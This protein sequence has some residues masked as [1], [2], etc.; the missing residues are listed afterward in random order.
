[1]GVEELEV[2]PQRVGHEH[3]QGADHQVHDEDYNPGRMLLFKHGGKTT[4]CT[5][6]ERRIAAL[7]VTAWAQ[8]AL[9]G[10]TR[11]RPDARMP[12]HCPNRQRTRALSTVP[13][14]EHIAPKP[15]Q[16]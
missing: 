8:P 1:M 5:V 7:G 6:G 3:G 9:G 11:R 15:M 16:C 14:D 4:L 10:I 12:D 13:P 2:E